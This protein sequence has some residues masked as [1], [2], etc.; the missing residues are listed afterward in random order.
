MLRVSVR[1]VERLRADG[2][3]EPVYIRTGGKAI[4]RRFRRSDVEA[5]VAATRTVLSA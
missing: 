3:L 5:R 4:L 2:E 1:T